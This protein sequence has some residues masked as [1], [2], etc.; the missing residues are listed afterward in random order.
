MRRRTYRHSRF[1]L[2][3]KPL[4]KAD[5]EANT[6]TSAGFK[7]GYATLKEPTLQT[8]DSVQRSSWTEEPPPYALNQVKAQ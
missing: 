7:P 3:E 1:V 4:P 8:M 6:A 5:S 2:P